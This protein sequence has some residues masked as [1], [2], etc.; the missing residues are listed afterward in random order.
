MSV[1]PAGTGTKDR[2]GWGVFGETGYLVYDGIRLHTWCM[3]RGLHWLKTAG[4]DVLIAF[5]VCTLMMDMFFCFLS[6][7][8]R[9][10]RVRPKPDVVWLE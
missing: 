9:V 2:G 3:R 8:V 1:G 7:G 4:L 6:R 10:V 5:A